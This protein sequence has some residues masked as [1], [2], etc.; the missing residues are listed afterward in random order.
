MVAID[1]MNPNGLRMNVRRMTM[2]TGINISFF[3]KL[4]DFEYIFDWSLE[5]TGYFQCE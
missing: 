4:E 1:G 3:I 2:S 5:K